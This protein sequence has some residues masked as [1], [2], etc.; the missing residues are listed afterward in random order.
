MRRSVLSS[1]VA[2]GLLLGACNRGDNPTV[3][4]S[5]TIG[6]SSI[7]AVTTAPP[8]T[9]ATGARPPI[10]ASAVAERAHLTD[11][12]LGARSGGDRVV[13]EFDP[14]VPG[15]KIDFATRPITEDGSGEEVAVKGEAVLEVRMENASSA[16][17]DGENVVITYKGPRRIMGQSTSIVTEAVLVGDF[18]GVLIWVLGL[19]SPVDT[20][21]VSALAG[22]SRLVIDLPAP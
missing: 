18:E 11:V 22:P 1:V 21:T 6:G 15:Y 2:V 10:T 13:F 19:K 20:V 14:V 12:R 8:D 7:G 17:L 9:I 4:T 3:A 5:S 16:R